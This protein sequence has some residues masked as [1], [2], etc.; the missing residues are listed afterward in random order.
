MVNGVQSCELDLTVPTFS[1]RQQKTQTG[2][3]FVCVLCISLLVRNQ[4]Q[5]LL[6]G[7]LFKLRLALAGL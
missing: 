4:R 6:P 3:C 2:L 1:V 7:A 5:L